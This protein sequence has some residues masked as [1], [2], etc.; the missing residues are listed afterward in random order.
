MRQC[1][2]NFKILSSITEPQTKSHI[3]MSDKEPNINLSLNFDPVYLNTT[4][5]KLKQ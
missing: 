4:S 3:L 5:K 1:S 2:L